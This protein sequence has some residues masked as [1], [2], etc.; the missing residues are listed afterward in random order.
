M[1]E[2]MLRGAEDRDA[3]PLAGLWSQVFTPPLSPDQW[4]A[5]PERLSHTIVAVDGSGVVGSVYGLP[6][7]LRE[8]DGALADVHAIGS[9]AVAERA[10]GHGLAR[11]LV[12]ATL[13]SAQR[14]GADWA[15]LFTGTPEVYR[16]SGF[17][18]F[19]MRRAAGGPWQRARA[20]SGDGVTRTR[21]T[22]G[23]TAALNAAYEQSRTGIVLAP[24]RSTLD[25]AMAEVR[26]SGLSL[27]V[28]HHDGAVSGYAVAGTRGA[29]GVVAELAVADAAGP[30]ARAILLGAVGEDWCAAG[31]DRCDIA[32]PER[33]AD[34]A[35]LRAFAPGAAWA[36]D[37]TGMTRPLA[38]R[39]RLDGIRHFGA[40][41]Y[42]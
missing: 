16:S 2:P 37:A 33:A 3:Q 13:G 32:V 17:E 10:R 23:A 11:R 5:D 35:A 39:P 4:L 22:A 27:Y 1:T 42:F 12:A 29:T 36:P 28:L 8:S 41:D 6:K 20:S 31:V 40:A 14:R 7:R 19:R 38:R 30:D 25:W 34:V 21:M 26:L 15:L 18:T 24:E 9:V